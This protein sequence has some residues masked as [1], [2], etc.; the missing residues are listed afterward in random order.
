MARALV[1]GGAGFIGSHLVDA[2][3]EGG[4][5]VRVLDNLTPQVHPGKPGY[6]NPQAE[7]V[8]EDLR[9]AAVV[10][11]ALEGV[12]VV[13]HLAAA[14]G[15]GQSMYEVE[16]YV[17]ANTT[18]TAT[19]LQHLV[20][21]RGD[22]ERLVVA[23]SMSLYG[24]GAY[25]CADCGPVSPSL[26]TEE[27]LRRHEWE[28]RCPDCGKGVEPV[29][30]PESKPLAPTS[31]YAITKRDQEE[32]C[33]VVGRAYGIPT[34]A[35]RF[36]N[37]YGTRQSLSNPYTGVCAIFQSRIQ[38]GK[39][40]MVFEDGHQTRD[41]VSVHD[42][43]RACVLAG[44]RSAADYQ[45]I[46]VG[47]GRATSVRAIAQT[48]L[49][50]HGKELPLRIEDVYRAGDVRHCYADI[51]RARAVLGYEPRVSLEEGLRDLVDWGQGQEA[52]DRIEEAHGE[53]TKRGLVGR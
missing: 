44:D 16:A 29:P 52:M 23:S 21:R 34:V 6:L 26:R 3:V 13:Y 35:L 11:R 28:L 20:D 7:Y 9:D 8:F 18:A 33:L 46:N 43:V 42:V 47:T 4:H 48:L 30:T 50:I 24:E 5:E 25:R 38:N 41:F 17:D 12:E 2:L 45:A 19:L 10:P 15:V 51:S 31:V 36:Y 22:V 27:Q 37:V 53:L 14:V 32:L 39:P 1:T 49:R 40:P